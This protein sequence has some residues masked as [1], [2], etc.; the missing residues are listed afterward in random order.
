MCNNQ[1]NPEGDFWIVKE[2]RVSPIGFLHW[3]MFETTRAAHIGQWNG[4][5]IKRPKER[6]E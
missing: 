3:E 2:I 4:A 1:R 6:E 5:K